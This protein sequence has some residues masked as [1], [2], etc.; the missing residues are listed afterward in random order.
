MH[1]VVFHDK[2]TK[3]VSQKIADEI[4]T[5]SC[6]SKLQGIKVNDN[7]YKFSAIS[8]IMPIE[9]FYKEYPDK[10]PPEVNNQFKNIYGNMGSSQVWK[11]TGKAKELMRQGFIETRQEMVGES[12]GVATQK[13]DNFL[14]HNK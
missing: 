6:D 9:E 4:M 1:I 13:F 2:S 12:F 14:K 5:K 3:E 8:K 10:R 11:P 7:F